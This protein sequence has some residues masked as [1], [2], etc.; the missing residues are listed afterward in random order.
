MSAVASKNTVALA[1]NKKAARSSN[2]EILR[3]LAILAIIADHFIGQSG[4]L[5]TTKFTNMLFYYA[6]SSLSRVACSVFVIISAWFLVDGK[7]KIHRVIHTWLTIFTYAIPLGIF[8]ILKGLAGRDIIAA[9]L[10]PIER[11]PMWFASAYMIVVLL[12]P[13]LNM[14]IN[15]APRRISRWIIFVLLVILSLYTTVTS[16]NGYMTNDVWAMILIYLLTGYI[17]RYHQGTID[18]KAKKHPV[19]IFLGIFFIAWFPIVFFRTLADFNST[20]RLYILRLLSEYT[21]S[22]RA[23]FHSI[24]NIIM[25]FS[26]FFAFKNLK[27]KSSKIINKMAGTTLGIYCFH[28]IPVWYGYLWSDICKAPMHAENLHGT[29]RAVYTV[30]TIIALWLFGTIIELVRAKI[31]NLVIEDRVIYKRLCNRIDNLILEDGK[32]DS[33]NSKKNLTDVK[34]FSLTFVCIG[35]LF[36][37]SKLIS[38]EH[39]WLMPIRANVNL[40]EDKT[41]SL[42]LSE[43][44]QKTDANEVTGKVTV[45]NS[46]SAIDSLSSGKYPIYLGVSIVD[47]NNNEVERDY[48]HV[49]I[50]PS[51]IL[52]EGDSAEVELNLSD[53]IDEFTMEG[54]KIRLELVQEGI[55]WFEGTA[56][57]FELN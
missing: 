9:S 17:K 41:I 13:M 2:I 48:I 30:L 34:V 54:Y 19:L 44:L 38:I 27:V 24:P 3:L 32:D 14:L 20:S 23:Q 53:R 39:Y 1:S 50:M 4:I 15:E 21:D 55:G 49:P 28:Q 56:I 43:N 36:A 42:V 57:Y 16:K 35:V 7:F 8:C 5:E 10:L 40:I 29:M 22:Y 11:S 31:C 46:G 26:L 37:V 47:E 33:V 18:S 51:G 45:S 25:A 12:S 6:G 52:L